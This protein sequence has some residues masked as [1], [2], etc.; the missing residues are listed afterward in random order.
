[1]R[2]VVLGV[3]FVLSILILSACSPGKKSKPESRTSPIPSVRLS[4][5]EVGWS[6]ELID[7]ECKAGGSCPAQVGLLFFVFPPKGDRIPYVKCTAFLS[8]PD[9][10]TSNGHCDFTT[11]AGAQGYFIS[12]GD[13]REVR[14]VT[15]LIFK[16]FTPGASSDDE[17]GRPDV[18]VYQLDAPVHSFKPLAYARLD[19][20]AEY[21]K[22]I[23]YVID[24][25][26]SS[27]SF[28][29]HKLDC[30][31][32]RHE[33]IFP[34]SLSENPD[35]ISAFDCLSRRGNSGGPMFAPGNS[36]VQAVLQGGTDKNRL[37]QRLKEKQNRSPYIYER[38]N[39]ITATNLRCIGADDN[40]CLVADRTLANSRFANLQ[41]GAGERLAER[42][43][44]RGTLN[45]QY[46]GTPFQV[47]TPPNSDE[48][49]F[50][51]FY[52]P[53]CRLE[54]SAPSRI[55]IPLEL[56][57][58]RFNEWGEIETT[59]IDVKSVAMDVT[60]ATATSV[61]G[62]AKWIP[63]LAPLMTPESHPRNTW[64]NSFSIELPICA[65]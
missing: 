14:K 18:G 20:P 21:N 7:I 29:M 13:T 15:S 6:P 1:M 17:S 9:Q 53:V 32:R 62:S 24:N 36:R 46:V 30:L 22:L 4:M 38:H 51:M 58:M 39:S 57:S 3:S 40:A 23:G 60:K 48:L 28:V 63:A 43:P 59:T 50:E 10:I 37:A 16:K 65:R 12:A 31:V 26:E 8:A 49:R 64:G 41:R 54:N 33:G 25:G 34:F 11:A 42:P 27:T 35:V 45:V 55:V 61:E 56:I 47:V 2:A 19:Q 44:T 52:R 5:A